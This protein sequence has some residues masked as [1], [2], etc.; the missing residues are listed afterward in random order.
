MELIKNAIRTQTVIKSQKNDQASETGVPQGLSI[1]NVLASIYLE[2]ID[3]AYQEKSDFR[4]FRYVDD[5]LILCKSS[6]LEDIQ[7]GLIKRF[8]R[9]GLTIH[10]TDGNSNKSCVGSLT[11][12]FTY[13]G[14]S[15][16]GDLVTVKPGSIE[17]VKA[18]IVAIFTGY[19]YSKSKDINFLKWH[20]DLR[21]TGCVF[22][23]KGR[24]WLMFFSQINDEKLLHELD[25]FVSQLIQRYKVNIK[26][27]RFVRAYYEISYRRYQ[28]NYVPN[29]DSYTLDE[30]RKLLSEIF[31]INTLELSDAHVAYRFN[32]KI[33]KQVRRLAEDLQ[34]FS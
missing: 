9:L 2:N 19:K 26:P 25:Y 10:S 18:S 28:T 23:N 31:D 17:K 6:D 30:Q 13:L 27:K 22:K 4:Y 8:K 24:G 14:Y 15:F 21:I 20:L 12:Q 29:F 11:K 32:W 16:K 34:Q 7:T 3:R 5:I 33:D 1:S